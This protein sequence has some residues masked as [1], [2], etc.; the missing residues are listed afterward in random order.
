MATGAICSCLSSLSLPSSLLPLP[1]IP[2]AGPH[3]FPKVL[4]NWFT[5]FSS[6]GI[7]LIVSDSFPLPMHDN[8]KEAQPAPESA[9]ARPSPHT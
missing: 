8:Y 5:F 2:S 7:K 4:M 9:V 1:I 3:Q 6:Q